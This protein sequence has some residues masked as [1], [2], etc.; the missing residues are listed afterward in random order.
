LRTSPLPGQAGNSVIAAHKE[1]YGGTFRHIDQLKRGSTIRVTTGQGR[2]VYRVTR[3]ER[4]PRKHTDPMGPSA[5]NRLT[6]MTS[7]PSYIGTERL[8]AVA[9]LQTQVFATP[10]PRVNQLRSDELG[11]QG[12]GSNLLGLL[13]WSQL[14]LVAVCGAVYLR[15]RWARWPTYV[16]VLPVLALLVLLVFDSFT[17]LLP[18][19]L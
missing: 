5:D 6:L 4:V 8:V 13:A 11:L 3:V 7:A 1:L 10:G 19:T 2:A 15:R 17:A 9:S 16:V 12:D 14:L 18:S